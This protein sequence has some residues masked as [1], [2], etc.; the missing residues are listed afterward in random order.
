MSDDRYD[1]HDLVRRDLERMELPPVRLW[2]PAI[3][4][5]A[6][7]TRRASLA[8]PIALGLVLVTIVV[9][10]GLRLPSRDRNSNVATT[11]T[12][13]AT[14]TPVQIAIPPP[15]PSYAPKVQNRLPAQ[16]QWALVLGSSPG[17][18]GSTI[19][20]VPVGAGA[21]VPPQPLDLLWF[22]LSSGGDQPDADNLLREQLSPDGRRLV[23]S[24]GM[25]GP[26]IGLIVVD[27]VAGTITPLT[28]DPAFHD[29]SPAWNPKGDEIAF[30]RVAS[31]PGGDPVRFQSPD[32][33]LWVV[34]ADGTGLRRLLAPENTSRKYLYSWNAD[35]TAIAFSRPTGGTGF[36]Q[37][38]EMLELATGKITQLG[39]RLASITVTRGV[40]DWRAGSPAF[41]GAF[42]DEGRR[43]QYI[44]T[45]EG[46]LGEGTREVIAS[47]PEST[48]V[49]TFFA[50][51][52]RPGSNDLLFVRRSVPNPPGPATVLVWDATARTQR[53]IVTVQNARVLAEWDPTGREIVYVEA[54]KTS[55]TVKVVAADGANQRTVTSFGVAGTIDWTDLAL[56]AF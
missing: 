41:V 30:V 36:D 43:R 17:N 39:T 19:V 2:A 8:L 34:R 3:E 12:P 35:G 31:K 29:V 18:W 47:T 1:L 15:P 7:S 44:V 40:G 38:Y 11:P 9:A 37:P 46:Q 49:F 51:R 25:E 20:A 10:L 33:G 42:T 54:G 6:P 52:W 27:L 22:S 4:E 32:A 48:N 45:A 14:S 26:R 53:E 28:T 23:L 21:D 16:G 56:V 55:A 24:V 50:A 5:R 13:S